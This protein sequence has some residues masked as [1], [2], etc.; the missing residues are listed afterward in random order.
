MIVSHGSWEP[1]TQE[2]KQC[3]ELCP[4]TS[5]YLISQVFI[6]KRNVCWCKLLFGADVLMPHYVVFMPPSELGIFLSGQV[7]FLIQRNRTN[8]LLAP[9]AVVCLP[10]GKGKPKQNIDLCTSCL[11]GW[12]GGVSLAGEGVTIGHVYSWTLL[13]M[14]DVACNC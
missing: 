11:W 14:V 1:I 9:S 5:K 7:S 10:F 6:T 8:P 12:P 13:S 4:N 3:F 2:S